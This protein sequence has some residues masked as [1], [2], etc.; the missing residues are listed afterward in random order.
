[1][2]LRP[3]Q[4]S[5]LRRREGVLQL[6][7]AVESLPFLRIQEDAENNL[8]VDKKYP[9]A[10]DVPLRIRQNELKAGISGPVVISGRTQTHWPG[11]GALG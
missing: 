6:R 3:W 9:V 4:W 10:F 7:W 11:E 5:K 1:M 2:R 8:N